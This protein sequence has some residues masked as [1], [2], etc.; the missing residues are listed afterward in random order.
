MKNKTY[1]SV[2]RVPKYNRKNVERG[3]L[4]GTVRMKRH[5]KF[6]NVFFSNEVTLIQLTFSSNNKQTS[7]SYHIRQFA[8]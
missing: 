1:H 8:P 5:V 4:E 6:W 7:A 3:R 2:E